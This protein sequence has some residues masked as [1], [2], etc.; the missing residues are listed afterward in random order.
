M[1]KNVDALFHYTIGPKLVRIAA[2][3][4]LQPN[5]FGLATN[6]R[7]KPVLWFS[8]NPRWEPTANKPMSQDG[9]K[10]FFRP[11][12]RELQEAVGIYR[13]RLDARAKARLEAAGVRVHQWSKLQTLARYDARAVADMVQRA[14]QFG[15]TPSLWWGS[16]EPVP[17][18]LDDE[19]LLTLEVREIAAA[20]ETEGWKPVSLD[21]AVRE[22]AARGLRIAETTT[23]HMPGARNL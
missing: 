4:R 9:G 23:K 14:L 13:F 5:G 16:L 19:P 8:A 22:F 7:E 15:A 17:L 11:Q 12:L 3:G 2:S 18:L 1:S 10:T 6:Q 20:G 21:D